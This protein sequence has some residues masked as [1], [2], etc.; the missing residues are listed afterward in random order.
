MTFVNGSGDL[1]QLKR[2]GR[3]MEVAIGPGLPKNTREFTDDLR[4]T[5]VPT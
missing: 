1:A 5:T 3:S 4:V 2:S